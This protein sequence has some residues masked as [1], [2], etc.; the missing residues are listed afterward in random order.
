M[1][2]ECQHLHFDT[3]Q[4]AGNGYIRCADCGRGIPIEH[5]FGILEERIAYLEQIWKAHMYGT[6][7]EPVEDDA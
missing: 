4:P 1:S 6:P 7:I 2:R 5:A 3:S